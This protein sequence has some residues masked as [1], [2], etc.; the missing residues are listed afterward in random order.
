MRALMAASLLHLTVGAALPFAM[1]PGWPMGAIAGLIG[2][3]WLNLR[4]HPALGFGPRALARLTWHSDGSWT[5]H[6][7]S[8]RKAEAELDDSSLTHAPLLVL[9]FKLKN[10]G[11]RARI[12]LGDELEPEQLR[13]LRARLSQT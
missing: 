10:G 2:F 4:R 11:R 8:D 7:A 3:S 1:A 12:L 5:L 6:D 9:N 13:R